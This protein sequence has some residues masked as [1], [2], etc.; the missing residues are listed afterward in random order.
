MSYAGKK[1][2]DLDELCSKLGVKPA[3]LMYQAQNIEK[4]IQVKKIPKMSG[5]E[6]MITSPNNKLKKLQRNVK[7]LFFS[8]YS[9]ADYIYGLGGNTLKDH[10]KVHTGSR[11][12]VKV[13]LRDFYPSI[14]NRQVYKMWV[15]DFGIDSKT[16][17]L[18]TKL[19]TLNGYL[20][21]GFPTS[22][23]IAAVI[24]QPM[25]KDLLAYC[26]SNGLKFSQ[27]VDDLN[28]SGK[29]VTY[30]H[31]FTLIMRCAHQAGFS[32]KRKK[33]TV[34]GAKTGKIITGVSLVDNRIRA[35]KRI[36]KK[37]V[38]S[39]KRLSL[40]PGDDS[41][42]KTAIGYRRF[43]GHLNKHDGKH[44]QKLIDKALKK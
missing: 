40:D 18:L 42:R 19:T 1:F 29:E 38:D 33:T 9:Y 44:Y 8:N 30:K 41:S 35:P 25:G 32:V 6:R 24:A 37:V 3:E 36:R 39:I 23:H 2:L 14:T 26:D 43:I 28:F 4:N 13:D 17:R 10:A 15:N 31:M 20:Q 34:Y 27:Y 5:G 22:S 21:Q 11:T 7:N 12:L 16:A